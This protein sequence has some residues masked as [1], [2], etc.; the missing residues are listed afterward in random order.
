MNLDISP[1][2]GNC[3]ETESALAPGVEIVEITVLR[4]QI[5]NLLKPVLTGDKMTSETFNAIVSEVRKH[6][7]GFAPDALRDD[8][9]GQ[10]HL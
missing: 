2:G 9:A 8:E 3:T 10:T 6:K 7:A 5:I 4:L 1:L